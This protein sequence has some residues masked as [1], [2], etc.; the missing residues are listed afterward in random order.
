MNKLKIKNR[1]IV[2]SIFLAKEK[3]LF[4]EL[5]NIYESLPTGECKHCN[6]CCSED[7]D[8]SFLEFLNIYNYLKSN[9]LYEGFSDRAIKYYMKEYIYRG[10]CP[11]LINNRCGIYKVRPLT[12]RNF[13]HLSKE[14]YEANYQGVLE[15]NYR[16]AEEFKKAYGV[17]ISESIIKFKIPYCNDF[18]KEQ[19]QNTDQNGSNIGRVFKLDIDF[20]ESGL[21]DYANV[22]TS[23]C[24]WFAYIKYGKDKAIQKRIDV[25]KT[26]LE[27]LEV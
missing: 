20:L 10:R 19:N 9:E 8:V 25:T 5:N 2:K 12:C 21:L 7:V 24:G 14:D 26:Y 3:N 22:N 13:G 4:E 23:L 18:I 11:F 15:Q 17:Q 6:R 27:V 1:N 16:G